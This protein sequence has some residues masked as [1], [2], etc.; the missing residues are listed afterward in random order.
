MTKNN[1]VSLPKS[2]SPLDYPILTHLVSLISLCAFVEADFIVSLGNLTLTN[3]DHV[4]IM[5]SSVKSLHQILVE[6]LAKVNQNM[7]AYLGN[8]TLLHPDIESIN[9]KTKRYKGGTHT[10]HT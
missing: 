8:Q 5:K 3:I 10:Q 1:L 4:S 6:S 9:S 2:R 7:L